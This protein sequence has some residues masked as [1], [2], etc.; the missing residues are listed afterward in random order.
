MIGKWDYRFLEMAELVAGWSKDPSTQ[1]GSVI[2]DGNR[3]V[4]LGFNGFPRGTGDD[5]NLYLNRSRK[6]KRVIHA[7]KNALAFAHRK[8]DGCTIYITHAPCSPCAAEIIQHGITRIVCP[9][10][11]ADNDYMSRWRDDVLETEAMC[12]EASIKL[13]YVDDY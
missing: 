3:V 6:I 5:V 2:V 9:N 7:E 1:V 12:R 10:P 8:L 13:E 11:W 4:S